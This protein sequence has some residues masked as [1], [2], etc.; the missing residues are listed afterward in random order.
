MK[1]NIVFCVDQKYITDLAVAIKSLVAYNDNLN[2]Y[3]I[4]TD[5]SSSFFLKFN[6]QLVNTNSTVI[7]WKIAEE[8]LKWD[9][10]FEYISKI[11]Y[12]RLLIPELLP[13]LK[14]ALYLDC[15]IVVDDNLDKL[16]QT[17]LQ[18]KPLGMAIDWFKYNT[19]TNRYN[20]GVILIDCDAWREKGY[21]E[22]LKK[23]ISTRI[24]NNR[25]SD[26]QSVINGFFDDDKIYELS[27]DYNAAYGIDTLVQSDEVRDK[28]I[29][30]HGAKIIHFTGPY[31]P[32]ISIGGDM[33]G[34]DKWWD[35][36]FMSVSDALQIYIKYQRK[37]QIL[38]YTR[39]ENMRGIVELAQAFPHLNIFIAAP[40]EVSLKVLK[41]GKYRNIYIK[42]LF[43]HEIYDFSDTKAILTIGET[44][45]I[46]EESKYFN[47]IGVPM[48]TYKDLAYA[49]INYAYQADN[50]GDLITEIKE[51]YS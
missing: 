8:E 35:F 6:E 24:D 37:N 14:K 45:N 16:F 33:R 31:K 23:E 41:L 1:K 32:Y 47:K 9:A 3:V 22:G 49:E 13:H 20:S 34:S 25:N 10:S 7:D 40:T 39:T 11:S 43:Q 30:Y 28:F 17:D 15:D 44:G 5:I 48:L 4:N 19:K 12:A 51:N 50:I 21:V 29:N 26:D 42:K 36:Y 2:I 27:I 18:G 46:L 38:V